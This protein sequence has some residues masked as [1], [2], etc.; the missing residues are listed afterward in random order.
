MADKG[1]NLIYIPGNHDYFVRE[2]LL[3]NCN[4]NNFNGIVIKMNDIY[5]TRQNKRYLIMHGDEFDGAV[6]SMPWLYAL[7]D[8]GYAML[9]R[10]N[11]FQNR[12]RRWCGRSDWSLSLW[13]KT[14]TKQAL[15]F[16]NNYEKLLIKEAQLY[17]VDGIICGHIHKAEDMYIDAI[18]YLN[19]GCFTEFC[20]AL[21]EDET[22][23]ITLEYI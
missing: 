20:S 1:V 11:G 12:I 2:E 9:V 6:R 13:V 7:G 8:F 4:E 10:V 23:V 5:T 15:Q 21:L 16:I 17:K 3:S 14:K 19:T 18:H 22:G